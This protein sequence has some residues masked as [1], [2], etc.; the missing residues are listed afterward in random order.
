VDRKLQLELRRRHAAG[1]QYSYGNLQAKIVVPEPAGLIALL[2]GVVGLVGFVG[3]RR[4]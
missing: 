2:S 1:Q 3:R 4:G